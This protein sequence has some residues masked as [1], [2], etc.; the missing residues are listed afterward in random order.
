MGLMQVMPGTYQDLRKQFGLGSNPHAPR[1]NILA[2]TA[3]LQQMYRR[4]GYPAMFAAYNAGP[5]RYE[6]YLHR[7]RPLPAETIAYIAGIAPGAEM[8]FGVEKVTGKSGPLSKTDTA[9]PAKADAIFFAPSAVS[10]LFVTRTP[11]S[12]APD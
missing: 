9:K 1:D 5:G 12:P 8:R 3:Y 7:R 2:G 10:V 4:Y 6:D 11:P